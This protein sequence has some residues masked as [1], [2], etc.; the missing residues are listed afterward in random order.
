MGNSALRELAS[1]EDVSLNSYHGDTVA[2]D[3]HHWLYKQITGTVRYLDE[4]V[5]TA[6]DGS[7]HANLVGLLRGLPPLLRTDITPVF[8]FDGEPPEQKAAELEARAAAK[9][10]ARRKMEAADR[11]GDTEATRMWRAQTQSLTETIHRTTRTFLDAVGIPY[12]EAAG[13]GEAYAAAL[14]QE[15]LVDAALTDDYDALL[16]GSP[17]TIRQYSGRGAAE[18][19]DFP[20]TLRDHGITH[21]QLVD[22]ALLCGTDFNEG[23]PGIGPVRGLEYVKEYG[24]AA[25]AL[26]E[27]DY[28][29]IENLA[30]LRSLFVDPR[31][32]TLPASCPRRSAPQF[33]VAADCCTSHGLDQ[34]VV[35]EHLQ[36]FPAY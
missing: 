24:R 28:D 17:T 9:T 25:V 5:Y 4:D 30:E 35:D 7:E 12:I 27:K 11:R 20:Q 31:L 3:A 19:M 16:F 29:P 2:V 23:V 34:E 36:R 13:P 33:G 1:L 32:G 6:A 10:E 8:V 15:G 21:P 14:V 18:R 22:V 26:A